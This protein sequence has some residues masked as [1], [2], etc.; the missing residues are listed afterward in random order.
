M[1]YNFL[2]MLNI[3]NKL[4]ISKKEIASINLLVLALFLSLN[5]FY[6]W[7]TVLS[8]I[9]ALICFAV[10]FVLSKRKYT[11]K[12]A[13]L[14]LSFFIFYIYAAFHTRE[15]FNI[16]GYIIPILPFFLFLIDEKYWIEIYKRVYLVFSLTI[17]PS[18]ILY[19]LIVFFGISFNY[20]IIQP[21][22]EYKTYFY[23]A[24]PFCVIPYEISE[25]GNFRFHGYYDEP[26]VVG[27]I[28][29][30][31]LVLNKWNLK[32]WVNWPILLAGIFSFS[33]YFYVVQIIYLLF[34]NR[35]FKLKIIICGLF[36]FFS[37]ALMSSPMLEKFLFS[38][39]EFTNGEFSGDNRTAL[40]FDIFYTKFLKSDNIL[41][42]NG[43]GFV[44]N[45]VS[46]SGSS[47]KIFIVEYGIIMMFF[48]C[49]TYIFFSRKKL[50]EKTEF[51]LCLFLF[52]SLIYQR[53]F[54]FNCFY[55]SLMLFPIYIL[56]YK[57]V[58]E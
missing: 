35:N 10:S 19:I 18:L 28:C 27:T 54:L 48:F 50:K 36:I 24:Y 41:W 53:P 34:F 46:Q 44:V 12:S 43:R 42:G 51:L 25:F 57:E 14:L 4:S 29:A 7:N 56:K 3:T 55:V 2:S 8:K 1:V 17:I 49:L 20:D 58:V 23:K 16:A 11:I 31:F 37:T 6:F 52:F 33:L 38:R 21:V 47:Y 22:N 5:P 13:L 45:H 15:S 32:K 39:L 9:G 30:F 40:D 26:G